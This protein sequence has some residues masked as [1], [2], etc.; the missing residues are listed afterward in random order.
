M[1]IICLTIALLFFIG[2]NAQ[3]KIIDS[4]NNNTLAFATINNITQKKLYSADINGM[5]NVLRNI[6]DTLIVSHVGYMQKTVTYTDKQK[7]IYL[8][9]TKKLLP[10]VF[11][12]NCKSFIVDTTSNELEGKKNAPFGGVSCNGDNAL[13][14]KVAVLIKP[15]VD[16][17][18]LNELSF[19]VKKFGP[20]ISIQ[21]P[22]LISFYEVD[23]S[24]NLPGMLLSD[25]AIVYQP[26]KEGKQIIQLKNKKIIVQQNGIYVCF[27]WVV[28]KKYQWP[29]K[30]TYKDI[31]GTT[32]DS[33]QNVQ[34]AILDGVR[35]NNYEIVFYKYDKQKWA[36]PIL[37]AN[38]NHGTLKIEAVF[39]VC[40]E[41]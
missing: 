5:A 14:G 11:V 37:Y 3:I 35:S 1:K 21:N 13:D 17:S 39:S 9:P 12:K 16:N 28:D 15:K 41:K 4:S 25:E 29:M 32:V 10:L 20:K 18:E 30:Y 27:Q 38:K 34:G 24:N 26:S 31:N 2:T 23:D 19:W 8:Q 7:E 33:I 6:G 40:D 22:I 36:K